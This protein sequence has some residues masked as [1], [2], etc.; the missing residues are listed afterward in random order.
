MDLSPMLPRT[1]PVTVEDSIEIQPCESTE[2]Q[3]LVWHNIEQKLS[4]KMKH[5]S[6]QS[7]SIKELPSVLVK[8]MQHVRQ[9][10]LK[11]TPHTNISIYPLQSIR[12]ID[13]HRDDDSTVSFQEDD[14]VELI[15]EECLIKAKNIICGGE[16]WQEKKERMSLEG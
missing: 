11:S 9:Q 13:A 12:I 16:S 15:A 14:D 7:A 4:I 5:Y 1:K 8:K 2:D 10:R 6:S 3:R